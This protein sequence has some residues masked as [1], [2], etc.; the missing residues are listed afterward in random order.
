[1]AS[2]GISPENFIRITIL[3]LEK[4]SLGPNVWN[5]CIRITSC[6]W[7]FSL[8]F[9]W[10]Y[11]YVNIQALTSIL[12][13][14]WRLKC[15]LSSELKYF[16]KVIFHVAEDLDQQRNVKVL[17]RHVGLMQGFSDVCSLGAKEHAQV[18][19]VSSSERQVWVSLEHRWETQS[20]VN[21]ILFPNL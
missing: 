15:L 5:H 1:M 13:F 12:T 2:L 6:P 20:T 18:L 17:C 21:K 14:S 19:S 16:F 8:W 7:T 4:L 10:C 3:L 11:Q 9:I